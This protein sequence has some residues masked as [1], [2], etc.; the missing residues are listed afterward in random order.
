MIIFALFR[1]MVFISCDRDSIEPEVRIEQSVEELFE[2]LETTYIQSSTVDIENFF[3]NWNVS[4]PSNSV[5]FINQD[6]VVK[7][8]YEIYKIFYNSLDLTKLGDWEWGNGLNSN[9]RYVV[10]QNNKFYA[11]RLEK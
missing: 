5:D 7:E 2:K 9:C 6:K 4:V 11:I 10:V 1:R 3:K 8:I